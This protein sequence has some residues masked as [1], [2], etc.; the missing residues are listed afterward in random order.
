MRPQMTVAD[1]VG[2]GLCAVVGG[3]L[4]VGVAIWFAS[5]LPMCNAQDPNCVRDWIAATSGWAAAA[6]TAASVF[7]LARQVQG[8]NIPLI[9]MRM[10]DLAKERE[11]IDGV[12]DNISINRENSYCNRIIANIAPIADKIV[13]EYKDKHAALRALE[14]ARMAYNSSRRKISSC[15]FFR[16]SAE[17]S[18]IWVSTT[19]DI[20]SLLVLLIEVSNKI[21]ETADDVSRTISVADAKLNDIIEVMKLIDFKV[22]VMHD[23]L[24]EYLD[25][26]MHQ[27][28]T[29][30]SIT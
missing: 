23:K 17:A 19:I 24:A 18:D 21:V 8:L 25:A 29:R 5:Q 27:I 15:Q 7:Y 9:Q 20:D 10:A 11:L 22:E 26:R 3:G 4:S 16:S 12:A 1:R 2:F 30:I 6:L 13:T 14:Q 28:D